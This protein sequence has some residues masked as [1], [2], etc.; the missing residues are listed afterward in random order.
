MDKET[1]ENLTN[2]VISR[3]LNNAPITEV[4]RVYSLS[5]QSGLESLSE[6]DLLESVLKAGY[7]DILEKYSDLEQLVTGD[8]DEDCDDAEDCDDEDILTGDSVYEGE[9]E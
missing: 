6:G 7:T 4:L 9:E 3:V 8:Y 2:E 1:R 5:V